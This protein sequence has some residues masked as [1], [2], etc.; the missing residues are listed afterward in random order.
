MFEKIKE[1]YLKYKEIINYLIAGGA[2][3]LLSYILYILFTRLFNIDEIISNGLCWVICVLFAYIINKIFV[4]ESKK[5]D[6]KTVLKEASAFFL[7]RAVSGVMVDVGA[8]ALLVKVLSINDLIAK[9]I[10]LIMVV[11]LNYIFSKFIVFRDK[12][13]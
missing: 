1:I 10:T 6:K 8:F 3:T 11:I 4:F 12:K 13:K 2:T 9:V 7:M 5:K